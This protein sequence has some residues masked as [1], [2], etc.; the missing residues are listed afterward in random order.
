M[1]TNKKTN[2]KSAQSERAKKAA[3][4][5][6]AAK[7][8]YEKKHAQQL[9]NQQERDAKRAQTGEQPA[10]KDRFYCTNK[11]LYAELIKWRDSA[12]KPEDRI[13]S[14]ELGQMMM[15]LTAKIPNRNENRN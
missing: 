15:A 7:L 3:E 4:A 13:I 11:D 12:K 1:A 9:K 6:K 10:N 2:K 14:E 8:A 5:K